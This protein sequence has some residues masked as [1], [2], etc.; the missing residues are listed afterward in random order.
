MHP[1][2]CAVAGMQLTYCSWSI[3][4]ARRLFRLLLCGLHGLHNRVTQGSKPSN[5]VDFARL[6]AS[7]DFPLQE[8][9]EEGLRLINKDI[10]QGVHPKTDHVYPDSM[11][12]DAKV[13]GVD[14]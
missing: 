9:L 13:Q 2:L 11:V 1:A 12:R 14:L 3:A 8:L 6:H 7:S 10:L 4:I 5:E